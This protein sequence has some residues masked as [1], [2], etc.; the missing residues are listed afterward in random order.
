[1]PISI[2]AA[3]L[4]NGVMTAPGQGTITFNADPYFSGTD[5]YEPGMW[6]H[7]TVPPGSHSYDDM[8]IIPPFYQGIPQ[9]STPFMLFYQQ[10]NPQDYVVFSLTNGNTF[11]LTSVLLA[12]PTSASTSP[13]SITFEGFRGDGSVVTNTFTTPGNG[14]DHFLSYQFSPDFASGLG[15]VEIHSTRWAMDNLAFNVPEPGVGSLLAVSLL[16]FAARKL[17]RAKR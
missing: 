9:S 6:F 15:S 11:G 5:Y 4:M 14:A 2:G 8:G 12:D 16:A 13:V 17:C 10:Y 3:I 1:M 7:V